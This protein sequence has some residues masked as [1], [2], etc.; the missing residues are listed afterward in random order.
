M[1]SDPAA[2]RTRVLGPLAPSH[3]GL[4]GQ[5]ATSWGV[6]AGLAASLVVTAHVLLGQLSSSLGFLTTTVFFLAGSLIG[7]LHGGILAYLGRPGDV[8]R[9]QALHR[10]A[11]AAVYALPAMVVGW[12]VAMVLALSAASLLAGRTAA[13]LVSLVG[14]AAALGFMAW[15][16][17]ETRSAVRNLCDRWPGARAL[18]IVLG[19]AFLVLV[20]IFVV[21][22]PE[23]WIVGVRPSAAAAGAMAMG[24]TLW[25]LGPLGV[26][27]LLGLRAW[28]R[29]RSPPPRSEAPHGT[30]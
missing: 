9:A 6:A 16:A 12:V 14:W 11:L 26:L 10:L 27:V 20:P 23:I 24:A 7:Y 30:E 13:L 8:T 4:V 21:S 22:R 19:L 25:I 28:T 1:A 18:F 17:V 2:R 3:L 29:H 15:A 5:V